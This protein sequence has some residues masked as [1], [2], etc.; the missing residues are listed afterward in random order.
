MS[1]QS[2]RLPTSPRHAWRR[3]LRLVKPRLSLGN[4]LVAGLA[5]ALG[6][7]LVTQVQAANDV[8]LDDLRESDLVALLDDVTK[9]ADSLEAEIRLLESD[10]R[11]LEEGSSTEA[12][13]AAESRLTSLQIL[14]GTVPVEGPGIT[15]TVDAPE[16]GF[17]PTMMIDLMQEL[18]NAGAEAI[19]IGTVRVVADTWI[20][21]EDDALLV[22]GQAV[23]APF[24]IVALGDAHTLS[25]AMAIPG[26]F[27]D[28]VRGIGGNVQVVEG[29]Q[30]VI[31]A[32][33][34]AEEPRYA[35]PVPS[36]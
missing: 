1:D 12:A 30:L 32:L 23:E 27:T 24:R 18:R 13:E 8:A 29:D 26:G 34:Q 3:V 10:R 33:H 14:S 5:V 21:V 19:Q 22:D 36:E 11:A 17:T 15:M 7:A 35:R 20:G 25:G 31:D 9:R 2:T 6:F 4:L 16:G 28:S